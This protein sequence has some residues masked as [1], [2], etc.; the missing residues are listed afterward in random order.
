MIENQVYFPSTIKR[1]VFVIMNLFDCTVIG[2]VF[3]DIIVQV[4]GNYEQFFRGGTT[5][6][7]LIKSVLGGSGNVAAGLSTIG[8]ATAFV[9]KAGHDFFGKSYI[10]DLKKKGVATKIFVDKYF[11][12][13]LIIAFLEDGKQRSF[14]VFR[15]ANDKLSPDEIEKATSFI[16]RSNYLYFSGYSLVNDTQRSAILRAVD[17]AKK[18][19]TKIIFDPGA[20]NLAKSQ[21]RLFTK[22]L[23]SCDVFSPNLEEAYAI[24]NVTNTKDVIGKLREK[25]PLTALKCGENG[26]ILI[27]KENVVRVP[28]YNVR[29]V[30]PTGAGD[31]FSAGVIY[32]LCRGLSLESIGQLANWF[33]AQVV[34]GIGPRSFPTKS[35]IGPFLKTL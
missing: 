9:G 35:K 23:S 31:A 4:D 26:C 18:F 10:R 15:G 14:L 20:F 11:P 32:G 28:S 6:C 3:I 2:D 13:G 34:T 12:T 19:K 33:A 16:K 21:K 8:G 25:V 1:W 22:L 27:S 24:T 30:D 7:N 5:Y 29:S 17:L